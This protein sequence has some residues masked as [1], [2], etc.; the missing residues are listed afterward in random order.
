MT[1]LLPIGLLALLAL[2]VIVIL[3]LIRERRRRVA[4][5]S[6][7]HW[8]TL[9]RTRTGERPRTL[10][11]TLLLLLHLLIA[12]L[13]GLALAQ[14]QILS[15]FST[16]VDQTA[17]VLDL[18]TSMAAS[19]GGTTRFETARDRARALLRDL[20]SG[21]RATLIAAGPRARVIAS[22]AAGDLPLLEAALD[23]L[24]PGGTGAAMDE[25]LTLAAGALDPQKPGRIV[26]LTDGSLPTP[27]ARNL[28]ADVDWRTVGGIADNRAVVTFAAR[29][30]GATLQVYARVA[31]YAAS[32]F[33]GQLRLYGDEQLLD[34]RTVT[35]DPERESEQTWRL[36]A[37][38]RT[39]R[40]ELDGSDA[41]AADDTARLH[42]GGPR[43]LR[44]AL[45][46]DTP[47]TLRRALEAVPGVTVEPLATSAYAADPAADLTVFDGFLPE[48]WPASA[49]LA[50]NPPASTALLQ[51]GD[52]T[53]AVD[54]GGLTQRS[55]L[56]AG[57]SFGG[58]EFGPVP[59][60]SAP[61]WAETLLSDG[62]TPLIMR[63]RDGDRVVVVWAFDLE[64]SNLRT[65][66]AFPLLVAR[67]VRDL[68]PGPLPDAIQAGAPLTLR[69]AARATSV[70]LTTPDG[71]NSTAEAAPALTLDT[72]T[73]PG[74]YRVV[75]QSP[76]GP[77]FD[78][79]VAVNAGSPLE[80]DLR[81]Q[82]APQL[83]AA[84]QG[85]A[86]S[87]RRVLELWP[88]LALGALVVLGLEWL[89]THR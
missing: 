77:L 32:P 28:P 61:P 38:P 48:R 11:I 3:H 45:V 86:D 13:L 52:Q 23:E 87:Q 53:R 6:L 24:R 51:V 79:R 59:A 26:V 58:V 62:E 19:D 39:L 35:I 42:V 31:N 73:Q 69:P 46:S 27:A 36:S 78:G 56:L 14:P 12:G 20:G 21:G 89:Y 57:L 64:R 22:G 47:D 71:Q 67:T 4:V 84:A 33:S 10:P 40:V 16:R 37:G 50:V 7:M 29:P 49:V 55:E 44:V 85:E 63:G 70:Q 9:P 76:T 81:P 41:L 8:R 88:W 80:S 54:S 2:P 82:A 60:V 25:A 65:R 68:S 83:T 17:I 15:A 18:S 43:P 72:L 1:F 34:T 75:E 66:L 74:W 30:L 5:P